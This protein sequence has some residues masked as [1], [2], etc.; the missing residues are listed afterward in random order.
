MSKMYSC[1][2]ERRIVEKISMDLGT[3][4]EQVFQVVDF[5]RK[6]LKETME[7]GGFEGIRFPYLGKFTVSERRLKAI[8][9]KKYYEL[10]Q[11]KLGEDNS[12]AGNPKD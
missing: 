10:I 2:E 12:P 7:K 5:Q 8:N 6:M 3:S 11:G 9:N 4:K 1:P